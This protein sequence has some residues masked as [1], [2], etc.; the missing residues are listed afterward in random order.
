MHT[1]HCKLP[2]S[3][4]SFMQIENTSYGA[5]ASRL[6][7]V[8]SIKHKAKE[9]VDFSQRYSETNHL[10]KLDWNV[11]DAGTAWGPP[12]TGGLG[13]T[14]PVAPPPLSAALSATVIYITLM[15]NIHTLSPTDWY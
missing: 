3:I 1:V 15:K 5:L 14:A 9:Q 6:H 4:S 7:S 8:S 2:S 10:K 11:T 12:Y 13:Q